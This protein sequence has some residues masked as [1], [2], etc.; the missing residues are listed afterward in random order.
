MG[1]IHIP[2]SG[3]YEKALDYYRDAI[4]RGSF[5]AELNAAH[6]LELEGY[7]DESRAGYERALSRAEEKGLP[8]FHVRVRMATVLPR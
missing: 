3:D 4:A 8:Q 1:Y 6:I 7:S 5:I 2:Q